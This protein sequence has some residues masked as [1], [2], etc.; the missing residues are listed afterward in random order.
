MIGR[1]LRRRWW[2]IEDAATDLLDW[3]PR[4]D[5]PL[6]PLPPAPPK[7]PSH[8]VQYSMASVGFNRADAESVDAQWTRE[9]MTKLAAGHFVEIR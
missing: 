9:I 8:Y 6:K 5:P 4:P 7:E 3:L 2:Q 1:W